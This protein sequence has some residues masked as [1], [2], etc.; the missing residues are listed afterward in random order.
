MSHRLLTD[1]ML[2]KENVLQPSCAAC[3]AHACSAQREDSAAAGAEPPKLSIVG[4][5][6]SWCLCQ[7][8]LHQGALD[9]EFPDPN[10]DVQQVLS[11]SCW[12]GPAV[13]LISVHSLYLA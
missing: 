10:F 1:A 8:V 5:C 4:R 3:R 6:C 13:A 9:A 7:H 12:Q 2:G 11:N